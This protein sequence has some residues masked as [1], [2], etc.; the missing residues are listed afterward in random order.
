[1]YSV[2][3][4]FISSLA[5]AT[6]IVFLPSL[7]G[8]QSAPADGSSNVEQPAQN[9]LDRPLSDKEKFKQ[10]K[11]LKQEL[12][13]PYKKWLDEDVRWIITDQ[14]KKAFE[15][16]SNDEEREAFIENFWLRRN[17]NPDSPENEFKE[18]HYRRIAYVNE[19]FTPTSGL[20][21]WKTDRGRIYIVYGP[22]DELEAHPSGGLYARPLA[23]GGGNAITYAFEQWH[24]KYFE[25]VGSLTVEF[26]DP[27]LS[28]EFRMTLDP[29][30]KYRKP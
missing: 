19:H 16:L 20:P 29:S 26:V 14:E 4:R 7:H 1:M 3:H 18:E 23:E 6:S 21:G 30:E 24:Y 17:P 11:E 15:T 5:L 12:K 2:H 27:T 8:Q 28:G 10:Q 25:G 9:P 13:G 22:P